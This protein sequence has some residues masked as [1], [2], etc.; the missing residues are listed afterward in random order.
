MP[1]N[2][3]DGT[4]VKQRQV[5]KTPNVRDD[6][7]VPTL[8][9]A[10]QKSL[11]DDL[12]YLRSILK[13]IKGTAKYD[14]ELL[15]SLEQ[16]RLEMEA[17][18]FHNATLTGTSTSETPPSGDYS[19]RIATTEFV[20]DVT[21]QVLSGAPGD[22]RYIH[23][24][25]VASDVWVINHNLGKFPSVSVVDSSNELVIGFLRYHNSNNLEVHFESAFSGKA[26]LN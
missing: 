24:Q 6:L 13:Q 20:I 22:S 10:S 18:S 16:L 19:D 12:N 2:L 15:K 5:R 11:E 1:I 14:S 8:S 25:N 23:N 26:Y 7:T 9:Y 21:N 17:A 3:P 4:Q